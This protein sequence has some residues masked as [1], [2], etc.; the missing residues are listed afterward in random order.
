MTDIMSARERSLRMAAVRG[1]DNKSTEGA[2]AELLRALG[3]SGWRRQ[4][5]LERCRP[6]FVFPKL[7][8]ALFADGCFW[9]GCPRHYTKPASRV[10]YWRTK[11]EQ[12]MA[13]DRRT[14]ARLRR[15][16][17]SVWRLWEC[18][19]RSGSLRRELERRL[20]TASRFR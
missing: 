5:A 8:I 6:D 10:S 20:R 16:G 14:S 19:I 12:N 4:V 9:H 11:I 1:R 2:L 15:V 3:I 13:R 17:W 7:R 18:E